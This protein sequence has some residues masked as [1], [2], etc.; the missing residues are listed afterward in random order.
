MFHVFCP[1]H[2]SDV[3]LGNRAIRGLVNTDLG[4]IVMLE[5]TCGE[6]IATVTGRKSQQQGDLDALAIAS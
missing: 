4:I 3:V 2:G 6:R 1:V 5:C